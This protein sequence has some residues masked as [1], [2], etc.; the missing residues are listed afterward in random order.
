[1]IAASLRSVGAARS[2]VIDER[3]EVLAGNGVIEAAAEAGITKLRVVD[4][5]GDTVVA[6]RRIGL[7]PGQKR[8]LAL[9]DNR[10]AELAE[11]DVEQLSAD[12]AAGLDFA[13]FF[14]ADELADLL[15][16]APPKAGRTDP[17][18]VPALRATDIVTGDLFEL[19]SHRLLCGD[20]TAAADVARL[21]G[22]VVPLLMVTDPPY[23]VNYDPAWRADLG[24]NENRKKLGKVRNDDRADWTEAWRLFGGQVAYVWH[25]ALKGGTVQTSLEAAG[26]EL[27]CQIIWAKDR[28][29]LSRGD[30][31]WQHETCWYAVRDGAAGRRTKDRTQTT[32]WRIS[33]ALVSTIWEIPARDDDGHGHGTQKP[34]ECMARAM[35]NHLA[36]TVYDCFVG[37][38][39]SVIAAETLRRHCFAME[40]EPQYCQIVIDRWEAFTGLKAV[41]VGEAIRS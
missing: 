9:Y 33:S 22:S 5:D 37:S 30:Y 15:A 41:K 7:T 34:V 3:N 28:L 13:E 10:A 27:R 14:R 29:V 21:C 40:L 2:I 31:H 36:A 4:V 32:L 17:D 25:A 39:T 6:V 23:G 20:S 12:Q 38:G 1:M 16:M 24:I 8:D 26:F 35:R 11:W 19:G 18:A